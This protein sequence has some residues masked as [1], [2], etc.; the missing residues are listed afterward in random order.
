MKKDLVNDKQPFGFV[1]DDHVFSNTLS[2][3]PMGHKSQ[4]ADMQ[5]GNNSRDHGPAIHDV[6]IAALNRASEHSDNPFY[7]TGHPKRGKL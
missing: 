7:W 3:H 6:T 2:D 1:K 5:V 4:G